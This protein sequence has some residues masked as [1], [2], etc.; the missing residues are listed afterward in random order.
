ME[1]TFLRRSAVQRLTGLSKA[2]LYRLIK[3]GDFPRQYQLG[4]NVVGWRRE[5]VA[6]WCDSRKRTR[7]VGRSGYSRTA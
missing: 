5:E 1:P 6:Q 4:P 3:S 2:S 7:P